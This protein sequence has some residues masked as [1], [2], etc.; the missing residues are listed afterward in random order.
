MTTLHHGQWVRLPK[1]FGYAEGYVRLTNDVADM[2][3]VVVAGGG[4][5][6]CE[7]KHVTPIPGPTIPADAPQKNIDASG[8]PMVD[9]N[10]AEVSLVV[11]Y[12]RAVEFGESDKI[13]WCPWTPMNVQ[14]RMGRLR[15]GEHPQCP[16]HTK[17]GYLFGFIDHV[18]H[19]FDPEGINVTALGRSA[20]ESLEASG[21]VITEVT[22][23][24][25][26]TASIRWIE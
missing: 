26:K 9:R 1:A 3:K 8:H 16:V 24:D 4:E 14:G 18:R 6:T 10:E 20:L 23:Q 17:E 21:A 19:T 12:I 7:Q 22:T 11:N 15:T 5:V 13:C 2:C 25:N